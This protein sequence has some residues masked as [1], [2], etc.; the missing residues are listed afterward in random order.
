MD[1]CSMSRSIFLVIVSLFGL[2]LLSAAQDV[3]NEVEESIQPQQ[4]PQKALELLAPLLKNASKVHFY[5]ET[6]GQQVSFESKLK[7]QGNNYS[8][9]F[10]ADGSLMDV[11]QTVSYRSLPQ[12]TRKQVT[13]Y[14]QKEFNRF[15][16]RKVQ[17]QF[18]A[19]EVDQADTDV[20]KRV[21]EGDQIRLTV[22]YEMEIDGRIGPNVGAYELLFNKE[23][24]LL[25]KRTVI[26]RSLD[27]ILY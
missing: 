7:W 27:N 26:R 11:E 8:I 20:M 25:S 14:L 18:S 16:V 1:L 13:D 15:K 2:P 5:R 4:M 17:L 23:G 21:M 22:R 19:K 6:D 3:K 9:E 24:Q 10:H 12:E